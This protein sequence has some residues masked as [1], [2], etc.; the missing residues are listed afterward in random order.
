MADTAQAAGARARLDAITLGSGPVDSA[1]AAYGGLARATNVHWI[2][3]PGWDGRHARMRLDEVAK[4]KAG[5]AAV[6][7]VMPAPR[8]AGDQPEWMQVPGNVIPD[9][10]DDAAAGAAAHEA[11]THAAHQAAVHAGG[12]H[13]QSRY[14]SAPLPASG[15]PPRPPRR[16]S[17][18]LV[19]SP[20]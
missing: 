8:D 9:A 12:G 16:G 11:A 5:T 20:A 13:H 3:Y 7:D 10:V 14:W 15:A 17:D 19:T 6:A 4:G 18:V 2:I 1:Q